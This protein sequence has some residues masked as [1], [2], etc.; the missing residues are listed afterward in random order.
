MMAL[1]NE[2]RGIIGPVNFYSAYLRIWIG[3]SVFII[4]IREGY[5]KVIKN[6]RTFKVIFGI[7][8]H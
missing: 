8:S 2:E 4:D 6:R 7:I 3:R 1:Q 5:K